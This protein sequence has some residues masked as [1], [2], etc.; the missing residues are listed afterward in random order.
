[1]AHAGQPRV[2]S[3]HQWSRLNSTVRSQ[4]MS[5]FARMLADYL[6]RICA[7]HNEAFPR[8]SATA[9]SP[10]SPH[11]F[12][13]LA[14][15][16]LADSHLVC[17]RLSCLAANP[18]YAS[19]K[20]SSRRVTATAPTCSEPTTSQPRLSRCYPPDCLGEAALFSTS[21]PHSSHI[22]LQVL[23]RS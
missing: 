7:G 8:L 12:G 9:T 21:D 17:T 15:K 14:I 13:P 6:K 20:F 11:A 23:V 3:S 19:W 1:M 22:H 18:S 5:T 10:N 16:P 4:C 2:A